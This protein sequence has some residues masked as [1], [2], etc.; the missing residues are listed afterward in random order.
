ML[1]N[2]VGDLISYWLHFYLLTMPVQLHVE[3]VQQDPM[4]AIVGLVSC[5]RVPWRYS[6]HFQNNFRAL[7]ALCLEL[8]PL[9]FS[10]QS[11]TELSPILFSLF[12]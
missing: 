12:A 10:A 3:P 1:I 11:S 4:Q 2:D 9:C 8:E 7:S 5:S 6:D